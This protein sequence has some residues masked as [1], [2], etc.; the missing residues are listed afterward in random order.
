MTARTTSKILTFRRP[1]KLSGVDDMQ[2]AGNY[3][4]ETDEEQLDTSVLAYRRLATLI[5]L[6]GTP[7]TAEVGRVIDINPQEL[8]AVL[9]NDATD[10]TARASRQPDWTW[11]FEEGTLTIEHQGATVSLGRYATREFAA[12]AAAVYIAKH[13]DTPPAMVLPQ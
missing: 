4:V 12:K 1:F 10:P 9:E 8:E 11:A 7:G 6:P 2:P 3:V 13:A 5:R